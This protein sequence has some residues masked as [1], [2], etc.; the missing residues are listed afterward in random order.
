MTLTRAVR[1]AP[2]VS[3]DGLRERIDHALAEFVDRGL[4]AVEE[5]ACRSAF[6]LVRSYVLGGGKRLRPTFCYWGWRGADGGDCAEIV[7]A[8]AALELFHAFAMI[9]DD[10]MDGSDTRRGWPSMHRQLANLHADAGWRGRSEAFG[11]AVAILAGDLCM[12][13][14]DELLHGSGLEP[15]RVRA[16][17]PIYDRMRLDVVCG[18]YLDIVETAR[19]AFSIQRSMRVARYKAAK[20]TVEHPLQLGGA[21]AGGGEDLLA[22]YTAFGIPL[23]EAFQ[24]RDDMIGV[25]GDPATTGKSNLDDLR[26]GKPTVLMAYA[27]QRSTRS[28][29]A[30]IRRLHGNPDLDS[31]G[32][33]QL[34][35]V[36]RATGAATAVEE[37]INSRARQALAA[38]R[39][40]PVSEEARN[41]LTD[42][43][44]VA[45]WRDA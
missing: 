15:A 1:T 27:A 38:L 39:T 9:H 43:T 34:R 14:A 20:Y 35:A 8:A 32:A 29:K 13:W 44:H 30:V 4:T 31:D 18:Q 10:I 37:M 41:T 2:S 40:A 11:V 23:G 45:L 3:R 28:Q 42:L 21:L 26:E 7:R 36:L 24:L 16:A 17:Q 19:R 12:A 25:F 6:E 5:V 22:A 33:A